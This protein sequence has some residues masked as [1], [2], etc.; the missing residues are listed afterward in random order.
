MSPFFELYQ[1]SKQALDTKSPW[2]T[3]GGKPMT[4]VPGRGSEKHLVTSDVGQGPVQR[5]PETPRSVQKK[6]RR[7]SSRVEV[8]ATE[9]EPQVS[10]VTAP[11]PERVSAQPQSPTPFLQKSPKTA[12]TPQKYSAEDVPQQILTELHSPEKPAKP[13]PRRRS[14]VTSQADVVKCEDNVKQSPRTSPRTN[15]GQRFKVQDILHEIESSDEGHNCSSGKKR[16][17]GGPDMDVPTPLPKRKRVSFG[18]QLSPELFDKRLPPDSPLRR[19][20]SPGRR[21]LGLFHKPQSLLRRASAGAFLQFKASIPGSPKAAQGHVRKAKSPSPAKRTT[22]AKTPSPTTQKPKNPGSL[23]TNASPTTPLQDKLQGPKSKKSPTEHTPSRSQKGTKSSDVKERSSPRSL[24]AGKTISTLAKTPSPASLDQ[25][26]TVRGRFSVSRISTPSPVLPCNC[27]TPK[28]P[29]RRKSMKA[30]ST[31]TPKGLKKGVLE[32]VRSRRSGAS[33]ANLKVMSSWADIVKFGQCL[34]Q[35]GAVAKKPTAGGKE[36][37]R[38]AAPKPKTPAK[39]LK[40][41]FSTG[42]ADSPATIVVGRAHV[43]STQAFGRAPKMVTNVAIQKKDMKMDEDL[44][45][46]ADMFN[47]PADSKQERSVSR[48]SRDLKTPMSDPSSVSKMSLDTPEETGEMVVSPL[49]VTS[50]CRKYNSDAVIRLLQDEQDVSFSCE[51]FA[52]QIQESSSSSDA[53]SHHSMVTPFK[54]Q[55]QVSSCLTG[56][57]RLMK[58]PKQKAQPVEDLRGRL[59]RTPKEPKVSSDESLVGLKEL[60]K[61]PKV[62]GEPAGDMAGIQRMKTPRVKSS[63]VVCSA[64]LKRLMKSPKLKTEPTEEDLTGVQHLMKTPKQKSGPV[65]EMFGLKRLLKTPKEKVEPVEDLTGVKHLLK[66]PKVKGQLVTDKFGIKKLMKTPKQKVGDAVEDFAGVAELLEE[67]VTVILQEEIPEANSYPVTSESK[68]ISS[69]E[70]DKENVRP[71]EDIKGSEEKMEAADVLGET[72]QAPTEAERAEDVLVE[73]LIDDQ[74]VQNGSTAAFPV[75][76]NEESSED[77]TKK[78]ENVDD[79]GTVEIFSVL[80]KGRKGKKLLKSRDDTLLESPARKP[81]RGRNPKRAETDGVDNASSTVPSPVNVKRGGKTSVTSSLGR[82]GNFSSN[83]GPD[84]ECGQVV[85]PV[86]QTLKRGRRGQPNSRAVAVEPAAG[87][88]VSELVEQRGSQVARSGRGR[89]IKIDQV[90]THLQEVVAQDGELQAEAGSGEV[91]AENEPVVPAVKPGRG[92]KT[93]QETS[94]NEVKEVQETESKLHAV[95]SAKGSSQT[96]L[97][98]S[99]RGRRVT[100]AAARVE[101]EK[102]LTVRP[103]RGRKAGQEQLPCEADVMVED[104]PNTEPEVKAEKS[105]EFRSGRGRKAKGEGSVEPIKEGTKAEEQGR[106]LAGKSGR[107]RRAAA[108]VEVELSAEAPAKR[109]RRVR[110]EPNLYTSTKESKQSQNTDVPPETPSVEPEKN[111][112]RRGTKT[113][114]T[115]AVSTCDSSNGVVKRG[116]A[117][118]PRKVRVADVETVNDNTE[119]SHTALSIPTA[120]KKSVKWDPDLCIKEV[121]TVVVQEDLQKPALESKTAKRGRSAKKPNPPLTMVPEAGD[122]QMKESKAEPLKETGSSVPRRGRKRNVVMDEDVISDPKNSQIPSPPKKTRGRACR[123]TSRAKAEDQAGGSTLEV[124]KPMRGRRKVQEEVE[125][126]SFAVDARKTAP[127]LV[128]TESVFRRGRSQKSPGDALVHSEPA[129]PLR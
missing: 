94:Q 34:P 17:S 128:S 89:R 1:I 14:Q 45:G 49:S 38:A 103:R 43:R 113:L 9:A 75:T 15:A 123:T 25:T 76:G 114:E 63:P 42:H 7:S 129:A 104:K 22:K 117:R 3:Q 111:L 46:V 121:A 96:P 4:P 64:A 82:L 30:S 20:A 67:P 48:K 2:K 93:K 69:E 51:P 97:V 52:S 119:Q 32:V 33:R 118:P 39:M 11:T 125:D 124:P 101:S 107:G 50:T 5:A 122:C 13:T 10:M 57:K 12:L 126:S 56:V 71:E 65:E 105:S 58:T 31:K 108:P 109:N 24:T 115:K 90:Q 26:P 62:K 85:I 16:K 116:R 98:K 74:S 68:E 78:D 77:G 21:S 84:S 37:K 112:N 127:E 72:Q 19:G 60:L 23:N 8:T 81:G 55:P 95:P 88:S 59:L 110:C 29:L 92:R 83:L 66:T 35:T 41:S 120:S 36:Q 44:T 40:S 18:G 73:T 54:Q 53:V 100:E 102:P 28:I 79:Q 61:T 70:E 6:Q 47:T 99:G 87:P 106:A 27:V 91:P 86:T 80:V